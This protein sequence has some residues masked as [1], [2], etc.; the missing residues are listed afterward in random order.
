MEIVT[1]PDFRNG[2]E[3]RAFV[4]EL[5]LILTL[6]GA[7]KCV[8]AGIMALYIPKLLVNVLLFVMSLSM[9]MSSK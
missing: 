9:N 2:S 7:C 8:M 5:Q 3:A 4:K 6:L 1:N